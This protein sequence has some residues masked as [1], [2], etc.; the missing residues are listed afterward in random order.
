MRVQNMPKTI[1]QIADE[2][3]VSKQAVAKRMKKEPLATS[4]IPFVTTTANGKQISDEGVA[5]I[6][7]DFTANRQPTVTDNIPPTSANQVADILQEQLSFMQGQLT[8][9]DEQLAEKDK[10]IADLTA[11][12]KAQAQSI[13]ADR[14]TQLAGVIQPQLDGSTGCEALADERETEK[15]QFIKSSSE[16]TLEKPKKRGLFG[17]FGKKSIEKT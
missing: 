7:T 17:I 13:N 3:G 14:H 5:L 6:C 12:V 8:A 15:P 4:L 2:I 10:Q 9:K 11:T 16:E 1:R